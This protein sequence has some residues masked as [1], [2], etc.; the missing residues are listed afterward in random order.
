[1]LRD[2]IKYRIL[3][4][5]N[6]LY[7][8]LWFLVIKKVMNTYRFINAVMKLNLVT[9]YNTNLLFNVDEFLE[10]FIKCVVVSLIN[11]FFGYN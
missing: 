5:Y 6:S 9:L 3:E 1:M 7:Q 10:E 2:C 11:F 4:K 8:N